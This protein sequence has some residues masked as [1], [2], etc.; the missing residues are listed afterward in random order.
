MA[1][2][3]VATLQSLGWELERLR[4]GIR[5]L[6]ARFRNGTL[7][8]P[9]TDF[10]SRNPVV[11]MPDVTDSVTLHLLL[12]QT[13]RGIRLLVPWAALGEREASARLVA[14]LRLPALRGYWGR[15]L[16]RGHFQRM[17]R[18]LPHAWFLETDAPPPGAVM[19]DLG[20]V[21]KSCLPSDARFEVLSEERADD[22]LPSVLVEHP[23]PDAGVQ[24]LVATYERQAGRV[25]LV[26]VALGA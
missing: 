12:Q 3:E 4:F 13:E 1:S 22:A 19:P 6:T 24:S 16:R 5:L 9:L 7:S 10:L 17:L 26:S 14:L 23:R 20:L 2:G 18:V 15:A 8:G 25:R 21:S 11:E